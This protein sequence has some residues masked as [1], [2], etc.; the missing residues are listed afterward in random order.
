MILMGL[1]DF[2]SSVQGR[3]V[4]QKLLR[5]VLKVVADKRASYP[6]EVAHYVDASRKECGSLMRRLKDAGVLERLQPKMKHSDTRLLMRRRE[7]DG[8]IDYMSQ[9]NWYGLNSA[10]EWHLKN[11]STGQWV[12][13]YH[14]PIENGEE[15][16]N[17]LI[18]DAVA[19]LNGE[20]VV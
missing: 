10:R 8:G 4:N 5:N 6:S 11:D 16:E 17:D 12:N 7:F 14:K 1:E 13:E 3:K 2:S 9:M 18:D 19:L 20:G 15:Y